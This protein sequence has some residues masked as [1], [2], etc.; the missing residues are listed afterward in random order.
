MLEHAE[1]PCWVLSRKTVGANLTRWAP[2]SPIENRIVIL[3]PALQ[4]FGIDEVHWIG[5][6]AILVDSSPK[7]NRIRTEEMR[8]LR[9][10]A[11]ISVVG[12]PKLRVANLSRETEWAL[13]SSSRYRW[14]RFAPCVSFPAPDYLSLV[15]DELLNLADMVRMDGIALAANLLLQRSDRIRQVNEMR[16]RLVLLLER[17]QLLVVPGV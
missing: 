12:D 10:V 11:A 13:D 8:G 17:P 15:V 3:S 5:G 4:A 7:T 2:I 16:G 9:E 6:I 1:S 14:G